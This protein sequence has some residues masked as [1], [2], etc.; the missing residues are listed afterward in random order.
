LI[1]QD[2][3]GSDSTAAHEFK[4]EPNKVR[5]INNEGRAVSR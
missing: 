4:I 2:G 5:M 1:E 3:D